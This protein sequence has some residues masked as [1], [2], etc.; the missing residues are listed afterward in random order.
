MLE[1]HGSSIPAHA[2][3]LNVEVSNN[4]LSQNLKL[5]VDRCTNPELCSQT[6]RSF[7]VS[8]HWFVPNALGRPPHPEFPKWFLERYRFDFL[9]NMVEPSEHSAHIFERVNNISLE[10][11]PWVANN[12]LIL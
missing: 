7:I 9:Q 1:R 11:R 3:L 2:N 6:P 4:D 8:I 10:F 5:F 12:L